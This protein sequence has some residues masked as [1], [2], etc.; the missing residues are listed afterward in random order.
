MLFE[1]ACPKVEVSLPLQIDCIPV[2]Y[3]LLIDKHKKTYVKLLTTISDKCRDMDLLFNPKTILTDFEKASM[4]AVT[5]VFPLAALRGCRFHLGQSWW[6][7]MQSPRLSEDYRP[8]QKSTPE[9]TSSSAM[10]ERP[11]ELDQRFQMEGG[12]QFEAIID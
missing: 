6:C 11:R 7:R 5:T 12:S 1:N 9:T 8:K 4:S 3:A 10:A 2:V